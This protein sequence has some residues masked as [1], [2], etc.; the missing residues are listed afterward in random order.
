[1]GN[2]PDRC[3]GPPHLLRQ[4]G[5]GA[6]EVLHVGLGAAL[7]FIQ[8]EICGHFTLQAGDVAMAEVVAEVVHLQNHK[9]IVSRRSST[10]GSFL[11]PPPLQSTDL[12]QLQQMEAKNLYRLDHLWTSAPVIIG[13]E[14]L[15]K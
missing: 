11:T 3:V 1:M 13:R 9:N 4:A 2:P 7:P 5:A 10:T 6:G 12:L 15:P 8:D 14:N